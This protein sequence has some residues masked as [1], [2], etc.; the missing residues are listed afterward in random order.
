M[1]RSKNAMKPDAQAAMDGMIAAARDRSK[2]GLVNLGRWQDKIQ[3]DGI[4]GKVPV[5]LCGWRRDPDTER[6]G[7]TVVGWRYTEAEMSALCVE[8]AGY[9]D[10]AIKPPRVVLH[11][12][13]GTERLR[14]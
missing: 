1:S 4:A 9:F 12:P 10:R 7:T 3:I 11:G 5:W 6:A 13:G 14:G 8:C 2:G